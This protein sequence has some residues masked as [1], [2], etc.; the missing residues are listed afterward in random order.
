MLQCSG[1]KYTVY[2]AKEP[3]FGFGADVEF[4]DA[5]FVKVAEVESPT[6]AQVF[7]ITNHIHD[8]WQKNSEV[9]WFKD[10][11]VRSTSV[12]DVVTDADGKKFR[13]EMVGWK[14]LI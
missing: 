9:V 11:Q 7:R 10:W 14:E 3:T 4:N 2:H 13:C 6:L 1:M 5:N 12:G 8:D